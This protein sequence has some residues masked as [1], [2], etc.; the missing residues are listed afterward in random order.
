MRVA[1]EQLDGALSRVVEGMRNDLVG[2]AAHLEV[3]ID[4]SEEDVGELD[5]GAL[6]AAAVAVATK[7]RELSRSYARGRILRDGFR[8]AITGKPNAGKSSLLNRLLDADRAIVT[9]V[10]GTTRDVLEE[11]IDFDGMPVVLSD[12]AG[13]RPTSDQVEMFGIERTRRE[14]ERAD[15]AILVLDASR[16]WEED[17]QLA[18]DALRQKTCIL[19]LNKT[20][21]AIVLTLPR[22]LSDG[23]TIVPAS[24]KLGSG[25]DELKQAIVR[26]AGATTADGAVTVTRER[27][28]HALDSAADGI[29]TAVDSLARGQPPDLVAVD[30][31]RALDHLGEIVGT[32]SCEDVL[33]RI[34][35]EFCVG[36]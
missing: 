23:F 28:K 11:S 15:L 20:D 7:L 6:G 21:L 16:P 24:M 31:M 33:D 18:L 5:R 35:R 36:K 17:D 2:I 1:A 30:I 32:T 12:T 29:A 9:E 25:I 34:F 19:L 13:I 4:F 14:L 26:L 3:A 8:V 22:S 27:Q 10:P